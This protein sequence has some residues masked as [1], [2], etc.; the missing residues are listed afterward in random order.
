MSHLD[1]LLGPEKADQARTDARRQIRD[2]VADRRTR[3]HLERLTDLLIFDHPNDDGYCGRCI[4]WEADG[5]GDLVME[6]VPWPCPT[7]LLTRQV[8][9]EIR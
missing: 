7:V 4:E 3:N 1:S 2:E 9:A 5:E 6:F 8:R